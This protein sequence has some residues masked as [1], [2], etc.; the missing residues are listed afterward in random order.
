MN[1]LNIN[2]SQISNAFRNF[3]HSKPFNHCI[4]D[5]F[6]EE[7]LANQ[8]SEEIPDFDSE[9]W[10]QYSN[11]IE[12]KKTCND[13]N[14]FPQLTY[15][16]FAFLNSDIFVNYMRG[17]TDINPLHSDM[18]LN[19]GGWHIHSNG[20]KLNPHLDYS[21]HPKLKLER[22]LNLIIYL[23]RNWK[24]EWGGHFGLYSDTSK[25]QPKK[26]ELEVEPT[27]N[28]AVFF[29]TTQNSW[30]G[31][32]QEVNTPEGYCRKSMAVYYL[33]QPNKNTSERGKALFAP[34]ENQ[35]EDK[36]VIDLIQKRSEIGD[37]DTV[38]RQ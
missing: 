12:L 1:L 27:F 30:H 34:T 33:T 23:E 10:H 35:K 36:T 32:S 16:A 9:F 2:T 19:G 11:A 14:K 37:A 17:L 21:M 38:Y 3:S 25:D 20:G 7:G 18:G 5:N 28:R 31:L 6:F 4:I 24:S 8:L 26:L 15:S 13:W 29:D 22:K